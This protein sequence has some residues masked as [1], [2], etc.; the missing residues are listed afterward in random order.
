[1]FLGSRQGIKNVNNQV[2]DKI[3]INNTPIKRVEHVK[4]LGLTYDEILSWIKHINLCVSRAMG[5]FVC[6][7]RYKKFL[8]LEAKKILCESMVLSQFNFGDIIYNN[9]NIY[10]QQK[11]TKNSKSLLKIYL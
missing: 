11:N 4:N 9:I 6:I 3:S 8:N 2:L 1:M 7:A 5:N 10:L